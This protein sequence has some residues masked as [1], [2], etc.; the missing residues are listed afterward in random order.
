MRAAHSPVFFDD[1]H[2]LYIGPPNAVGAAGYLAARNTDSMPG[3]DV[4]VAHFTFCHDFISSYNFMTA[5]YSGTR[6]ASLTGT[7]RECRH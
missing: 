6:C 2:F 3:L 7:L 5:I 1:L 4:F